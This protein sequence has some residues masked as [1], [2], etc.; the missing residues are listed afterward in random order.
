MGR[1]WLARTSMGDIERME[2]DTGE[3]WRRRSQT[4][5]FVGGHRVPSLISDEWQAVVAVGIGRCFQ[6]RA[7]Y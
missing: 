5:V 6:L 3:H 4:P 1:V 7:Y 2:K